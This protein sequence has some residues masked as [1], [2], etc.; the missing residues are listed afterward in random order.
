MTA[1]MIK[2]GLIILQDFK[3]TLSSCLAARE[4][5]GIDSVVI[6]ML[7]FN[8]LQVNKIILLT[9]KWL[10]IRIFSNKIN[11]CSSKFDRDLFVSASVILVKMSTLR[12]IT[13]RLTKGEMSFVLEYM[14]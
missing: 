7:I 3:D 10:K 2:S 14:Y 6:Q 8:D 5:Q 12:I 9:C 4:W 1:L 13:C 11:Y